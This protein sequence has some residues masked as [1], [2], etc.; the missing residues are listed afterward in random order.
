MVFSYSRADLVSLTNPSLVTSDFGASAAAGRAESD[1]GR[2]ET[3]LLESMD[4]LVELASVNGSVDKV[5]LLG[6]AL[7]R[8]SGRSESGS[9]PTR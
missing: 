3:D 7:S 4:G 2:V 9:C 6:T 5:I 1:E 8:G